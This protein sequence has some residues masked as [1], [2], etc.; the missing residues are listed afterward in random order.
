MSD[1]R[2]TADQLLDTLDPLSYPHRVREAAR[3]AA[4][5]AA[6]R[7]LAGV[8]A[9]L[10]RR[11]SYERGVGA[12]LA[13]AGRDADWV[14]A[15]LADPDAFVRG[16]A[17]RAAQGLPVPD[18]SFETA[19]RDAPAVVRAGILHHL[20]GGRRPALA[21]RLVDEVREQWGDTDAA[22]LLPGCSRDVV[23]RLLPQVF[24]AVRGWSG[25]ARR[26]PGALVDVTE[27]ELA[28]VPE[29][30]R[31]RWFQDHGRLL[32][33]VAP[34]DPQRVL[35]LFDTY[36][37][38]HVPSRIVSC[39]DVLAKADP[40]RVLRWYA[41]PWRRS[42]PVPW[43]LSPATLRALARSGAPELA[44][45]ARALAADSDDLAALLDAQAPAD[46]WATYEAVRA[47]RGTKHDGVHDGL[48]TALP[49]RHV[50]DV[51]RQA[52]RAARE[53]GE[54]W[55]TVLTAESFLPPAEAREALD[56]ATR[57]PRAEDRGAA[58]PLYVRHVART[59]DPAGLASLAGELTARL[60]NEQD[61]V[62]GAA[63]RALAD[64]VH[65]RLWIPSALP[66]LGRLVTDAL[67]ARDRS[68]PTSAAVSRLAL[69]ILR[70]HATAPGREHT[71]WA[72]DTLTALNGSSGGLDLGRLDR[73]LRRGQEHEVY[74]ALRPRIESEA[75]KNEY[76]L[77]LALAR[78][79]G[80]RA[81]GMPEL[82]DWLRH[83]IEHGND[84]TVRTAIQLWLEPSATR[85]TRVAHI[86]D[87]EPSAVELDCVAT[88]VA[89]R[90]TDLLDRFLTDRPPLGRF[91]TAKGAWAFPADR[92]AVRRWLPRQQ[93]AYLRQLR[94]IADDA[95]SLSWRRGLAVHRAAHVPDRGYAFV[96]TWAA[97]PD[98][99]IA[100]AA[101][102]ALG[103]SGD[104][105]PLLLD[106]AGGDRARVAVY[107]AAQAARHVSPSR[108]AALLDHLLT[109][110]GKK[111][112]S[113]KEGARLAAACLPAP[114]AARLLA[115]VYAAAGTHPDVRAVC[116]A[117]AAR[118]LLGQEPAWEILT[119]AAREDRPAVLRDAALRPAPFDIAPAHRER[120][121]ALVA[122]VADTDHDEL[123]ATALAALT[124]WAPWSPKAPALFAGVLLDVQRRTRGL[125]RTAAGGLVDEAGRTPDRAAALLAAVAA[126]IDLGSEPDAGE[127]RDRPAHR[128]VE[129]VA[130]LLAGRA[131]RTAALRP[132]ARSVAL[133]LAGH[134]TC[135][136][137]AT[138]VLLAT[139]D[140]AAPEPG[141][142]ELA[143][144]HADR[145]ALAA[146]TAEVL[147]HRLRHEDPS[148]HELD[149]AARSL[150]AS[151]THAEGL[152]AWAITKASGDRSAWPAPWRA[153]LAA[154]RRHPCPD[155]R[156]AAVRVCTAP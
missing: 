127:E 109:G 121:A 146:R 101:L 114:D 25:L 53:Q 135:T 145:P 20:A 63:L 156:D 124:R 82:Q 18:A 129:Y 102:S 81:A 59:G 126:L 38:D 144:L 55:L 99:V 73:T 134:D 11:G 65:P 89:H 125:W 130:E 1:A 51:A 119:D 29:S 30:A 43:E 46:R 4:E 84:T 61:P 83:A 76:R 122:A 110:P 116:V 143:R 45:C 47:G 111:V 15:H 5:L 131:P 50:A 154:L 48:L 36:P 21:D 92:S 90:R 149:R 138:Q 107:A 52:A 10:D 79:T 24:H 74:A 57:R 28:A 115:R 7:E 70:E 35:G 39:L 54:D 96:R 141:L 150:A 147:R 97:S 44:D 23:A 3:R 68:Y 37:P 118:R 16:H 42:L 41:G 112:T 26:H 62:R 155:V 94:R 14:A 75:A 106:H 67:Q 49:R 2:T 64:D 17:M 33:A 153:H 93:Q 132:A 120:Y 104:D 31:T 8:I 148:E 98:V 66:H 60:R 80:R 108:L 117:F 151:G 40:A 58:W 9:E 87:L 69:G 139:V 123:A 86:L 95:G 136:E 113:R 19:L 56:A 128:R 71:E 100:E 91:L 12:L 88:V 85:D 6:S 140:L 137:A 72:L 78:A 27:R 133:L 77:V 32:A 105:L 103:R 34:A 22:K 142:R 152:F 13:C